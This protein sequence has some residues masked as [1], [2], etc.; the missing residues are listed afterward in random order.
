MVAK[1]KSSTITCSVNPSA[2]TIRSQVVVTGSIVPA[3]GGMT[4]NLVFMA[5]NGSAITRT[6][7]SS[8]DDS[9]ACSLTVDSVGSWSVKASWA[10][11]N[12]HNGTES[13]WA[14]FT[15]AIL[16]IDFYALMLFLYEDLRGMVTICRLKNYF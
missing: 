2:A 14:T 3:H 16:G 10:G 5:S 8:S 11:D 6:T 1:K 9:Y 13:S 7:T 15:V 12:D 4:T